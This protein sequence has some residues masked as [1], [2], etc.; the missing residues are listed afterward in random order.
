[1]DIKSI[2]LAPAETSETLGQVHI[3][4]SEKSEAE[5]PG[6]CQAPNG[7]HPRTGKGRTP[8][9]ARRTAEALLTA[10][11]L[12]ESGVRID[13]S[14]TYQQARLLHFGAQLSLVVGRVKPEGGTVISAANRFRGDAK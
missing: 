10:V 13:N 2:D 14:M 11:Q 5:K 7:Q 4:V 1:M 8:D 9:Q 6:F 12:F 3:G